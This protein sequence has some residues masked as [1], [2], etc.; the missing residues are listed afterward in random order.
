M[1]IDS[2]AA[3]TNSAATA[4]IAPHLT[5]AGADTACAMNNTATDA[6]TVVT[7]KH[8]A[9]SAA[10]R[11]FAGLLLTKVAV[12]GHARLV[13][14]ALWHAMRQRITSHEQRVAPEHGEE[15]RSGASHIRA[16]VVVASAPAW[17]DFASLGIAGTLA[18]RRPFCMTYTVPSWQ[19]Q[20][21]VNASR[22]G[23]PCCCP[24]SMTLRKPW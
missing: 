5:A 11:S 24:G 16:S 17:G 3:E 13:A 23:M 9:N 7:V 14:R 4:A 18:L 1:D 21:P 2:S 20:Q 12:R 19:W 10:V 15:Q 6:S 22:P 8:A